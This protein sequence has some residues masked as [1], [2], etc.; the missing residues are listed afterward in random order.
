MLNIKSLDSILSSLVKH[1]TQLK[2]NT[3][4]L[5]LSGHLTFSKAATFTKVSEKTICCS[6][7]EKEVLQLFKV[8]NKRFSNFILKYKC[9]P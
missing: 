3:K 9:L 7:K 2:H 1:N 4:A 8:L 5:L 6:Q